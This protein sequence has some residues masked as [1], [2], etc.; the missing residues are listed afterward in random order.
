MSLVWML[1]FHVLRSEG[2]E[3][4][5]CV[6]R[7]AMSANCMV[8]AHNWFDIRKELSVEHQIDPFGVTCDLYC[9]R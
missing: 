2:I 8:R 5:A 7:C 6:G 1:G 4:A 3:T 9:L